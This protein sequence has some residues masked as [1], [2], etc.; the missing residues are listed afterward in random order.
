MTAPLELSRAQIL[1]FRRRVGALDGRLPP[2]PASTRQAA[3]AGLQDSM[4]RAALL[5]LH[6]RVAGTRPSALED[7]SLAQVWG[8]RFSAFVVADVD[9]P[10][11]TLGRFPA[12]ARGQRVASETAARLR[13]FLGDREL[14]YGEVGDALGVVA[15]SLRY[16]TTTGTV[17]IRWE[18]ARQPTIRMAPPPAIKPTEARLELARRYLRVFGPGTP[19][20]FGQWAGLGPRESVAAFD[21]LRPGLTPVRTPIG[22]RWI[23]AD[24]EP[25][26]LAQHPTP[27][28]A[29]LL[30]SGDA[31][32]LLEGADRE[33]LVP[34]AQRRGEL[35]T[36]RVWPG[37]VLLDGEIV[38]TWRRAG[39]KVVARE[40]RRL[41]SE[42]RAVVE[43][44][45]SSLPLLVLTG[46]MT[47][48][49]SR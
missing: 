44:E 21:G 33:L 36:P 11:F 1:A 17:L 2:G 45:A 32:Y 22:D 37:A 3:W 10:V 16:A 40:W 8:P 31:F 42:A 19:Q 34:D 39:P 25:A 29:R 5:S 23:L 6:A 13:E 49:W 43:A 14:P 46:P 7:D 47:L 18:G 35:W 20:A 24:D 26:I 27:A 48:E 38:G 41:G 28:G 30:P 9:V 12:D 4:P 15:N